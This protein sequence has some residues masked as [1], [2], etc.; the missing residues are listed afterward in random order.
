MIQ[1]LPFFCAAETQ[2][3]C[4]LLLQFA[5]KEFDLLDFN[6]SLIYHFRTQNGSVT[7]FQIF[8]KVIVD[9][10][11]KYDSN[12]NPDTNQNCVSLPTFH[13][14]ECNVQYSYE[15]FFAHYRRQLCFSEK[16]IVL[17]LHPNI[18]SSYLQKFHY[19]RK[20]RHQYFHPPHRCQGHMMLY[21]QTLPSCNRF[22]IRWLTEF[23]SMKSDAYRWI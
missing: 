2:F 19:L 15:W 12:A 5:Q 22:V 20:V 11:A 1:D 23:A 13:N 14:S 8:P 16:N 6:I 18:L 4:C 17:S 21:Q 9:A 10:L 7:N 3:P